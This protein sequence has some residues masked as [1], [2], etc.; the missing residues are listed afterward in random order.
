MQ[1]SVLKEKSDNRP[2]EKLAYSLQEAADQLSISYIS[3]FRLV[4][5]GKLKTCRVLRHHLIPRTEIERFLR[6]NLEAV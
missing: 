4:R 5:R 1:D 2:V 6:E 3:A